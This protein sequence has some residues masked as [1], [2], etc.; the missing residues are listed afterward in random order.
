[1]RAL[2]E[3]CGHFTAWVFVRAYTDGRGVEWEVYQCQTC[4]ATR[5]YAVR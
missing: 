3:T 1:M 4:R 2:C 5:K